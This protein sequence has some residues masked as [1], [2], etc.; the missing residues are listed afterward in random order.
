[1]FD[2]AHRSAELHAEL[3]PEGEVL[4]GYV[5]RLAPEKER[6]LLTNVAKVPGVRL[7][8]VGGGPEEERL[9]RL[10][11]DAAFLGVLHGDDLSRAY[12]TLDVFVHT[13]RHETYCQSAQEALASGVPVV[14]PRAG[15]PVDVVDD[16]VAG[17]LYQPGNGTELRRY[18]ESLVADP[19]LRA[20]VA[21]AAYDSVQDRSWQAV[22]DRLVEHYREVIGVAGGGER[23]V[24]AG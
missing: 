4:V 16:G 1:M 15:G 22:N 7:V 10:L 9:R 3:A 21:R 6:E 19:D 24:H 18:V 11:P 2:P 23:L 20:R 13:G 12:A 5:G 17:H 8:I 14:A